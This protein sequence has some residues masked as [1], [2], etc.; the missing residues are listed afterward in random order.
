[1][2]LAFYM[3]LSRMSQ[4]GL[5]GLLALLTSRG[6]P[7][8]VGRRL[9]RTSGW[10]LIGVG[11]FESTLRNGLTLWVLACCA[12]TAVLLATDADGTSGQFA[13]AKAFAGWIGDRSYSIY[14]WHWLLLA[15]ALWIL[16]GNMWAATTAVLL[17]IA[18][19]HISYTYLEARQL[20]SRWWVIAPVL[21]MSGLA[22]PISTSSWFNHGRSLAEVA[23]PMRDVG[24]SGDDMLQAV[25]T[26][27][28]IP[29]GMECDNTPSA[30]SRIMIIGDSLGYRSLPAVQYW[31]H[32]HGV[33]TTMM[34]TGGC[35]IAKDSCMAAVG[36][37]IYD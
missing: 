36:T 26:C 5:G 9:T 22:G 11:F 29:A 28:E 33:N 31:A 2:G 12:G 23:V 21:V 17:S 24:P 25:Q 35:T 18:S 14:L 13:R 27:H 8:W 6:V 20:G 37:A 19:G 1:M 16:P 15:T 10:I 30:E 7:A 4:L 34:W 3:P 32:R